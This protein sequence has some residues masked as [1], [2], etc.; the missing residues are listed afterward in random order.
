MESVWNLGKRAESGGKPALLPAA[1]PA[2]ITRPVTEPATIGASIVIKG[3]ITGDEP[4]FIDGTVEGSVRVAAHRVTVG[5]T[6]KL[7][8]DI[9]AHD[10]VVMGSVK[11]DIYCT[12]L[13]DVRTDSM[14][15]GQL[16][17]KSIR[18]SDGANLKGSVEVNSGKQAEEAEKAFCGVEPST[19]D[20]VES[21][22]AK[23]VAER[24]ANP[25]P[26]AGAQPELPS[27]HRVGAS[28]LVETS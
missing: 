17:A 23:A 20:A 24:Q 10:V 18:I 22:L 5:R 25:V 6:G 15:E 12:D 4:L 28:V 1:A 13:L 21:V 19:G 16:R 9:H 3:E 2:S 27:A 8:A 14:I 7:R 26:A 11:G